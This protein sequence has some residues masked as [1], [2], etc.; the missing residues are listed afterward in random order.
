MTRHYDH[1]IDKIKSMILDLG[2]RVGRVVED[3][4]TAIEHRDTRL[5]AR[6]IA[7]ESEIDVLEVDV[8]EEC[9]HALAL[10]QPVAS[11]LRFVLAVVTINKDLERIGDLAVNLAEQAIELA[12][13]EAFDGAPFDLLGETR[14]VREMLS[15]AL[16]ALVTIDPDLAEQVRRSDDEVDRIHRQACQQL[17]ARI[18]EH[19][20]DTSRLLHMMNVSRQLE[21]IADH[22]VSIAEDVFYMA[23]GEFLRHREEPCIVHASLILG[24]ESALLHS[25]AEALRGDGIDVHCLSHSDDALGEVRRLMPDVVVTTDG[26]SDADLLRICRN[27]RGNVSSQHVASL[28]MISAAEHDEIPANGSPPERERRAGEEV[29]VAVRGW[30]QTAEAVRCGRD[31]IAHDGLSIDRRRFS[32][33]VDGQDIGLTSTEFRILW[34]L[35][36]GAGQVFSRAQLCETC[37]S[38]D[39]AVHQR[40]IDVHIRAIRKKLN[41]SGDLVKTVRGV[42]YRLDPSNPR[43]PVL[44]DRAS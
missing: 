20:H 43:F 30:L 16:K 42:G 15:L 36:R 4:I 38:H 17:E 19:P 28:V 29:A 27:L 35:A 9:L 24:P 11:D 44:L 33:T 40:T 32:A 23:R 39:A 10:Y 7:K 1:Q 13:E 25:A 22:A 14:R 6:V 41:R 5:A 34:M 12:A 2:D 18:R 31:F 8:E 21:R 3:A 26:L 37:G